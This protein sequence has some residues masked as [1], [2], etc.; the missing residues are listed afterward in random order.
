MQVADDGPGAADHLA[1]HLELESEDPVGGRVLG[2][3]VDH[4]ALVVGDVV[5]EDVVVL[6]GSPELV[7]HAG[8]GLVGAELLGALIRR[9]ELGL[10][11]PRYPDL[12]RLRRLLVHHVSH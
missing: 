12:F 7:V 4:H 2:P 3:H 1:F 8:V 10:L 9:V 11:G 6:D 5:G